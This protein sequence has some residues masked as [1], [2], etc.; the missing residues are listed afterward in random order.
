ML[1]R[2]LA[3][4]TALLVATAC[5][6][7]TTRTSDADISSDAPRGDGGA[8]GAA[9]GP[10]DGTPGTDAPPSCVD[11]DGDGHCRSLDCD[12][13]NPKINKAQQ[14]LCGNAFDDNCD[15]EVD[16]SCTASKTYYIDKGAS[17]CSDSGPG[18]LTKPWCTIGKANAT[19]K[20][21]ETVYVRAGTYTGDYVQ[22]ASS[23]SSNSARIT[24][25]RYKKEQVT[26]Q[27]ADYAIRL[28]S[29]SYISV[30]GFK[31][32]DC[33]RNIY[34]SKSS[35]NNIGYCEI[36]NPAGPNTWGGSRIYDGSKHNKIYHCTFSRWGKESYNSGSYQ[37]YGANLDIGNDNTV[38]ASD[39]NLITDCTFFHGGHHILGI[40]ANYNVVRRS[41]F[42][43]EEWYSC[44]RSNIGGKCGNRNVILNSSQPDK[45]I[46]NIIE[47]NKIAFAG[48]P[49]DQVASTG[50]SLR[51]KANIIRR[52]TFDNNDSAGVTL[53]VDGS[54]HNDASD[55]YIYHNVFY[56]NGYMLL[57]TWG[58]RKSGLLLA[59][60]GNDSA[61]NAM[62]GVVIKNNI[63][64]QNNLHSIYYYYVDKKDL[65]VANNWENAGDPKF[66]D[67]SGKPAPFDFKVY[68]FSLK[69]S[70][71]CVDKGG[72]LTRATSA[73]TSSKTLKV[74]D[75]GYFT[76]G[77]GVMEGD[78]IQLE[79][80][81]GTVVIT[82][83]DH[84]TNTL[85]LD[86]AISW[87]SN[88]GVALPYHGSAPDQGAYERFVA[89]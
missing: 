70:S 75:A 59:R 89:P 83:V 49:P 16:E 29:R 52:N 68:D 38:D 56:K 65:T 28:Q 18:T 26:L 10:G 30:I 36:D 6:D 27:G 7:D 82:K 54:N 64:Y 77:L 78:L 46:G 50:L 80:V 58:P 88:A 44:H 15:G 47:E 85:T 81:T 74:Q 21:G 3:L 66:V 60:W 34:L 39:Y 8:D 87:K 67:I 2:T 17:A 43:N 57:D 61:H 32:K 48:V 1:R 13:E 31:F 73:G 71:P 84:S 40:Y 55:N 4:S 79:G 33:K 11:I 9:D 63:F 72:F 76:D 22:P 86:R 45:N 42:H 62:K 23:G 37:D 69:A 25:S 20:A 41:T 19:L 12:D 51:T 35:H 14:E 5:S 53:S 24:Y